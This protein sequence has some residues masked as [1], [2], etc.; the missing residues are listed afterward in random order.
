M[1][2]QRRLVLKGALASAFT[3]LG[4]LVWQ[5]AR[6]ASR[7]AEAFDADSV[8]SVLAELGLESVQDSDSITIKAP[9]IAENGAVVPVSVSTTLPNPRRII[10]VTAENPSPLSAVFELGEGVLGEVATRLKMG[11]TTQLVALVES[12]GTVYRASREV[13]V[14]IGGCGG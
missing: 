1:N 5:P 9:E 2:E 14:T 11:Q 8:D 6:G 4:L 3:G 13:K 7:P 12:E 10:I